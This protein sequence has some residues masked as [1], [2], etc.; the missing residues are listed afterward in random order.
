MSSADISMHRFTDPDSL[1][2]PSAQFGALS[3]DPV[4]PTS[5][6][7]QVTL[8]L[9]QPL[10]QHEMLSKCRNPDSRIVWAT[11]GTRCGVRN[12]EFLDIQALGKAWR[13]VWSKTTVPDHLVFDLRMPVNTEEK[14]DFQ[15]IYWDTGL[16]MMEGGLAVRTPDVTVLVITLATASR[17]R[18]DR[19]IKFDIIYTEEE[20]VA[21]NH[22]AD[23]RAQLTAL[24]AY[25]MQG[26]DSQLQRLSA[27]DRRR[28]Q[29]SNKDQTAD[30]HVRSVQTDTAIFGNGV[31]F[32]IGPTTPSHIT[33]IIMDLM[34]S[35][36][37]LKNGIPEQ[38]LPY[39]K[40]L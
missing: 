24:S 4:D 27:N 31:Q 36:P 29:R 12:H 20:G 30:G 39:R 32:R 38:L 17:M 10:A 34:D 23:L 37:C 3:I 7:S 14:A 18:S 21:S 40:D 11:D 8:V 5:K 9:L 22:M 25:K 35:D 28:D 6:P 19:P 2:E 13:Q 26:T 16:P 1:P 33:T 15:S